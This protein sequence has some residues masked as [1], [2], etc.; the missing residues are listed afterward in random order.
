MFN[1]LRQ[2]EWFDRWLLMAGMTM[3]D[4]P[5]FVRY[6]YSIPLDQSERFGRY[7]KMRQVSRPLAGWRRKVEVF[8]NKAQ[9]EQ[10]EEICLVYFC[11]LNCNDN[12]FTLLEINEQEKMIYH[13][14]SM[15]DRDVIDVKLSSTRVEKLV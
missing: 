5:Y 7:G 2:G 15:A 14:D 8:R 6:G 12:H 13:Y 9:K 10:G 4:K 1:R 3:L 11:P